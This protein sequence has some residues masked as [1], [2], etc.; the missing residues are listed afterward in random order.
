MIFSKKL[1]GSQKA[2]REAQCPFRAILRY[3]HASKFSNK[4]LNRFGPQQQL[5]SVDGRPLCVWRREARDSQL[6]FFFPQTTIFKS[7]CFETFSKLA[8]VLYRVC[9]LFLYSILSNS[10][11]KVS[12]TN[13][14]SKCNIWV[15]ERARDYQSIKPRNYVYYE[16]SQRS[17]I[18][19]L[20]P[21]SRISLSL[22]I[23]KY[24]NKFGWA[25]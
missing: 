6:V 22:H 15:R 1:T 9:Y 12:M 17:W 8:V 13:V 18:A 14:S 4:P 2:D 19:T 5:R 21:N 23:Q 10:V 7:C 20:T 24:L 25:K 11:G 3:H 16:S